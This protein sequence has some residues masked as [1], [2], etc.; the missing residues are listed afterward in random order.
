MDNRIRIHLTEDNGP[1]RR[2]GYVVDADG[3]VIGSAHD[4]T[5]GGRGYSVQTENFG[6]FVPDDDRIVTYV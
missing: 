2:F 4:C 3:N 1:G 6:G 5:Y